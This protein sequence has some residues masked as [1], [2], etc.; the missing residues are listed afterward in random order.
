MHPDPHGTCALPS[1]FPEMP[2]LLS[3]PSLPRAGVA[4]GVIV[5]HGCVAPPSPSC[6]EYA[7]LNSRL[8]TIATLAAVSFS[9]SAFAQFNNQ[10]VEFQL[11][12]DL[13]SSVY[14][15]GDEVD[16]AWADV[17]N[18][19]DIDLAVVIKEDFTSSGKRANKLLMNESGSL[20]DRTTQFASDADVSGDNGFRT[21]TNDRDIRIDDF[22]GDGWLD[23]VT[24]TTL[25]DGDPKHIGHPRVYRNKGGATWQGFRFEDARIPQMFHF[26]SGTA[27]NPRFCSV[28]TGDVTGDTA[29]E[30]Y[31]GDYDSSGAGGAQQGANED[32][33]DRLLINDGN[34]FFSDQSQAR[35]TSTMLSSAFGNSVEIDDFN[36][37]GH[38]DI[39]KDTSLNQPT[40]VALSYNNPTNVGTFSVFDNFHSFA[41]YHT[42]SGDLNNDGRVDIIVSDDADD[43]FR[44][45]LSTNGFGQ[46]NWSSALT[47]SFLSGGDDGFASN[48]VVADLDNDGFGEALHCDVDVDIGGYTR[49][50]HIYHNENTVPGGQAAL[51]E[52]RQSSSNNGWI[53]AVGLS[54]SDLGGM[55]DVAV[56]DLDGDG[57]N[58]LICAQG[59][60]PGGNN[61]RM[62][63]W[64]NRTIVGPPQVCEANSAVDTRNDPSIDLSICSAGG[65]STGVTGTLRATG[66][67]PGAQMVLF[68]GTSFL[69]APIAEL[70][71]PNGIPGL[72]GPSPQIVFVLPAAPPSGSLSLDFPGG[73]GSFTLYAQVFAQT[74]PL[75]SS[76]FASNTIAAGFQP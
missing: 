42:S 60:N 26:G 72:L 62:R 48:N 19:G 50:L 24:A 66:L 38:D 35:M 8:R 36:A 18:D 40:Y 15:A 5:A 6:L 7:L 73:G 22:D 16:F 25:S 41:P 31:F 51:K 69:G 74:A 17:D 10:W 29:P 11:K 14:P 55:H 76:W 3:C 33:N 13:G 21:P 70:R 47:Y 56:F 71:H 53:G 64:D 1:V 12:Q 39:L 23:M 44:Y 58:E 54:A 32:M 45:N 75:G 67:I 46:V 34:G 52:E 57:D 20:V 4:P 59:D 28:A 63:V 30:L 9:G 2:C 27:Q 49:R 65:L 61:N 37:D 68:A 43:R